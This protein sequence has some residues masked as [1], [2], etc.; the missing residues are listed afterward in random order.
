[1]IDRV[2]FTSHST[3]NVLSRTD[4]L[5]SQ[6]LGLI[7]QKQ[8]CICNKKILYKNLQP[9]FVTSYNLC[10]GKEM[11]LFLRKKVSKDLYSVGSGK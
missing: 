8:I 4:I 7:Q 2:S 3:Q 10:P 1:M 5:P 9:G 11:G 6:S